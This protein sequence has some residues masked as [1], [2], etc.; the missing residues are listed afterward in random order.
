[1]SY[2][3]AYLTDTSIL[4]GSKTFNLSYALMS[5]GRQKKIDSFRFTEGK[6][7]SLGAGL[8]LRQACLDAGL[9]ADEEISVLPSGKSEFKN[10]PDMHF[11]ISHSGKYALCMISD[12]KIGCDIQ[13][14]EKP[15][16]NIASR[17]F[18]EEE[19]R[20]L[21]KCK[22]P[23]EKEALFFTLWTLKESFVKTLGKGIDD[24]FGKFSIICNDSIS[25][26]QPFNDKLYSFGSLDFD[27]G[28]C[29]SY[30]I[31]NATLPD[32][33]N[34]FYLTEDSLGQC[35]YGNT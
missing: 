24:D 2:C 29:A 23:Q 10:H 16:L 3:R 35:L 11:S 22:S 19:N 5:G 32:V 15:R 25:V 6:L 14:F 30:C 28:Y 26:K 8:M 12:C 13:V 9:E 7:L 33:S 27:K 21:E 20:Q 34:Y 4:V 1:M 17:F 31:E 18:S